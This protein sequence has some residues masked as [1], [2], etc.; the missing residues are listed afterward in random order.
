MRKFLLVGATSAIARGVARMAAERGDALF[1][2]GRSE[3]KV[4][5]EAADLRVRGAKVGT[6]I[7]D[8]TD[9][10]KH[11]EL[12]DAAEKAMGGLDTVLIAHGTLTDQTVAQ[13]DVGVLET[14]FQT[15][16]LSSAAL[17]THIA[18]RFEARRAGSIA[19]ITSVAGDRGRQSNYVY[20]SA[21]A[22]LSAFLSGLRNRLAKANVDVIDI[23][24][25]FVD[26]PM[27]ASV[28]KNPLFAQPDA[29]GRSIYKAIEKRRSVVYLP[30]FWALIMFAVRSVP[31]PLFKKL[32][33]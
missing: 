17:L 16:F 18:N 2:V 15:N 33:L 6:F 9:L 5:A 26:T 25:G 8:L 3:S 20:G 24:P 21:K 10:S 30:W 32:K 11:V 23:R 14:E 19:V 1:L 7:M 27:T 28:P 4:N 29:V 12:L 13:K 31:E 22:A